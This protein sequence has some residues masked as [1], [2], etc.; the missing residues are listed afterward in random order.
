MQNPGPGL[1]G[2]MWFFVFL[3]PMFPLA[4]RSDLYAYFPQIGLHVVFLVLLGRMVSKILPSALSKGPM[5]Q[6]QNTAQ[7]GTQNGMVHSPFSFLRPPLVVAVVI[8]LVLLLAGWGFYLRQRAGVAAQKADHSSVFCSR[9]LSA[10]PALSQL[11]NGT[12]ITVY[13]YQYG[14]QN[15]PNAGNERSPH[16]TVAYGFA[17]MLNLYFPGKGFSGEIVPAGTPAKPG[18]GFTWKDN[19]LTQ[20]HTSPTSPLKKHEGTKEENRK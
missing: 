10:G 2:L 14:T 3:L 15:K 19:R 16:K 12:P 7:K 18:T 5:E 9:V 20:M 11:P 6:A 8:P 13:D 4:A 17:P 1:W